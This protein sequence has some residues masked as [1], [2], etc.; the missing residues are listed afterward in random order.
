MHKQQANHDNQYKQINTVSPY[1][2]NV[3]RRALSQDAM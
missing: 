2:L 1:A 3:L